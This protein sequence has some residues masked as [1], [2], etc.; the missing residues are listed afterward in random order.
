MAHVQVPPGS[1]AIVIMRRT[2]RQA[3]YQVTYYSAV[4]YPEEQY[5]KALKALVRLSS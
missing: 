1:N 4:V 2:D 5:L 3:S